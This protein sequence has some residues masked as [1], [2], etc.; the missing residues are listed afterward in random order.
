VEFG[1]KESCVK[2]ASVTG[3]I[4]RCVM[5]RRT[6]TRLVFGIERCSILCD[7]DARQS[8][9]S[10]TR[11]KIAC[12]TS[13][14]A[15]CCFRWCPL[16][17]VAMI[18]VSTYVLLMCPTQSTCPPTFCAINLN[19]SVAFYFRSFVSRVRVF[20]SCRVCVC[21]QRGLCTGRRS[22]VS[23]RRILWNRTDVSEQT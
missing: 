16:L 20:F 14:L 6:V 15:R 10:K 9:A 19:V 8:R 13:V 5:A 7:F 11:D 18:L 17:I 1:L 21:V 23:L 4:A 2:V 3:R 22:P 12:V